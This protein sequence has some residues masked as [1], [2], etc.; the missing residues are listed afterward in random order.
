MLRSPTDHDGQAQPHA[1]AEIHERLRATIT[2]ID[3]ALR[4]VKSDRHEDGIR[5]S[6]L[7]VIRSLSDVASQLA[8]SVTRSD[9]YYSAALDM[10]ATTR[11]AGLEGSMP[12]LTESIENATGE[13]RFAA[14]SALPHKMARAAVTYAI[15]PARCTRPHG[16]RFFRSVRPCA[17]AFRQIGCNSQRAGGDGPALPAPPIRS[18]YVASFS[19]ASLVQGEA[20]CERR[21]C[22][23]Q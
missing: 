3:Q 8:A 2:A 1:N 7:P 9:Q 17:L 11:V 23:L 21:W 14:C 12:D 13:A 6:L 10:A 22:R 4:E 5:R 16:I 20:G 15:T 18:F 19:L